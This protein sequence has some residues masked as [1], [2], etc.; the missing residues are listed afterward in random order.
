MEETRHEPRP[1]QPP[2]FACLV[3]TARGHK[4]TDNAALIT[5]FWD[6]VTSLLPSPA[7][8]GLPCDFHEAVGGV[9]ECHPSG[10]GQRSRVSLRREGST[11][12]AAP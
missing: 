6:W 7:R 10:G 5:R 1:N 11:G 2:A 4:N 8:I 9:C 3:A 12:K